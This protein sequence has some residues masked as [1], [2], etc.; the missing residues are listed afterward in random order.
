[1]ADLKQKVKE[2]GIS[3][4]NLIIISSNFHEQKNLNL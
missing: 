2:H 4:D 1:M 3:P